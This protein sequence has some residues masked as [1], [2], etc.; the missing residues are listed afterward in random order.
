MQKKYCHHHKFFGTTTMGEKGQVVIPSEAR[1]DMDLRK[2]EKLMVFSPGDG[3]IVL[4]KLSNFEEFAS[5][6][7]EQLSVMRKVVG[8]AKNQ[9]T[10]KLRLGK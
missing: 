7:S 1:T 2:G 4:S 10:L 3:M 9:P 6:L 8:K 5:H